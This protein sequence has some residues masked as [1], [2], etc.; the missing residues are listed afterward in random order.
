MLRFFLIDQDFDHDIL[1]GLF[2]HIP[3]LDVETA[4][5]IGMSQATD[6]EL[7]TWAAQEGRIVLTH[8]RKSMPKHAADL[9]VAGK[10]IAGL[11]IVPRSMP[12]RQMLDE[13]ELMITCSETDEWI[14]VIC[15][16][17]L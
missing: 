11:I 2:R 9:M 15:Y 14:N 10:N 7:L 5:E 8:D 6:P 13:L 1:R 3:G 16:L 12:L 17:P 4:F